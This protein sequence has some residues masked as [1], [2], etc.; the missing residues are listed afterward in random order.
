MEVYD[1][2]LTVIVTVW[3]CGGEVLVVEMIAGDVLNDEEL[4][5]EVVAVKKADR[6]HLSDI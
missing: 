5:E 4:T 1:E 6:V 3:G 2:V